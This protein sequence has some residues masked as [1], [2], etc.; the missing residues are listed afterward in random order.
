MKLKSEH[1]ARVLDVGKLESGAPYMVMEFLEGERPRQGARA[2]AVPCRSSP[3][4]TGSC[5]RARPSPRR[6]PRASCTATSSRRTCFSRAPSAAARRSRC[7]TSASRRRSAGRAASCPGS[8]ER[9]RCSARRSTWRRSRCARR[10]TSTRAPTSGRSASCCSSSSR[11]RWPFEAETMPELCLK[12]V[13]EPPQSLAALRPDVPAGIVGVDR[14]VPREG[15]RP[16]GSPTPPSSR[17]RS[18]RSCSL[19]RGSWRRGLGWPWGPARAIA[20][21]PRQFAQRAV[22]ADAGRRCVGFDPRDVCPVGDRLRRH[23][24]PAAR[25]EAIRRVARCDGRRRDSGRRRRGA[26]ARG[27]RPGGHGPRSG[28]GARRR[29]VGPPS[30]GRCV[31]RARARRASERAT[32]SRDPCAPEPDDSQRAAERRGRRHPAHHA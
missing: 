10:G 7:S 32:R 12:V 24:H 17:R 16:S 3:R 31:T 25:P 9:A 8:R 11:Q 14:A 21:L 5:R 4:P 13:T 22:D 19:R 18:S 28:G 6:T 2:T 26:P 27:T 1:V 29:R 30:V 23:S 20:S 15:P